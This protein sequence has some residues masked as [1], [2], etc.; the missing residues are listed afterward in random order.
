MKEKPILFFLR[1]FSLQLILVVG[2]CLTCEC[3]VREVC[4]AV[5]HQRDRHGCVSEVRSPHDDDH[6]DIHDDHHNDSHDNIDSIVMGHS[7]T[8]Q[9]LVKQCS[10]ISQYQQQ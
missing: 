2:T 5:Q 8:A 3:C 7:T 6:N 1:Y 9:G 10:V 4:E